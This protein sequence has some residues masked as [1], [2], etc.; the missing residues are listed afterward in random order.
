MTGFSLF[1]FGLVVIVV[2][3][4]SGVLLLRVSPLIG[5]AERIAFSQTRQ[6]LQNALLLEAAERIARGESS[7]VSKLQGTNPIDLLP[8]PPAN[9]LGTLTELGG[10][11]MSDRSWYYDDGQGILVYRPGPRALAGASDRIEFRVAFVYED[12]DRDGRFSAS[13]DGFDSLGLQPLNDDSRADR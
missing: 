1:E 3:A 11:R 8:D 6:R 5:Q 9:Y 10:G 7:T 2:T 13:I 4:L 12:R